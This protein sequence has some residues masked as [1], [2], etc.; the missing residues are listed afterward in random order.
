MAGMLLNVNS[1]EVA[2]VANTA[3]TILQIKAPDDRK[4][5]VNSLQIMGKQAAG[6]TDTPVKIRITRSTGSFGTGVV[7]TPGK[8]DPGGNPETFESTAYANFS[9]EPG[10]PIDTGLW[11]EFQPQA[12][13]VIYLPPGQEWIV[14]GGQSLQIEATSTGSP[15]LTAVLGY[16][17]GGLF[18]WTTGGETG[19]TLTAAT[20]KN[21][22]MIM[23]AANRRVLLHELKVMGRTAADSAYAPTKFRLT[24]CANWAA[25]IANVSGTAG[26]PM[27]VNPSDP[28]TLQTTTLQAISTAPG[29]H[30]TPLVDVAVWFYVSPLAGETLRFDPPLPIPGGASVQVEATSGSGETPTF[31][32]TALCEE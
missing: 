22:L 23:A 20:A 30:P 7:A 5:V 27:K 14:P 28:E 12:G 25:D 29:S 16:A 8:V 4:L 3:K 11:Y 18:F 21:M 31:L 1:G 13:L 24:S 10:A 17:E 26:N 9:G 15:T 32:V 2:L 19:Q 6:G